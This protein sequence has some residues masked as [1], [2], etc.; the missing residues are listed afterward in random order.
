MLRSKFVFPRK[1]RGTADPSPALGMTKRGGRIEGEPLL[2]EALVCSS[3]DLSCNWFPGLSL[4][5]K[6]ISLGS[7]PLLGKLLQYFCRR[8]PVMHHD[9]I[10]QD[11]RRL[12]LDGHGSKCGD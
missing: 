11:H 2:E 8:R 7:A 9:A 3:A 6:R 1:V 5:S 12:R 10:A 4:R